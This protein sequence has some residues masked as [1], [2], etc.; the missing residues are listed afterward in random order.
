[1]PWWA[2]MLIILAGMACTTIATLWVAFM[3]KLFQSIRDER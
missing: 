3:W 1:M 2:I